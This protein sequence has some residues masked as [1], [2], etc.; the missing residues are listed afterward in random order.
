MEGKEHP[1]FNYD[2]GWARAIFP[3]YALSLS[4][5]LYLSLLWALSLSLSSPLGFLS[6]SPPSGAYRVWPIDDDKFG[7]PSAGQKG[8]PEPKVSLPLP[9]LVA[10]NRPLIPFFAVGIIVCRRRRRKGDEG[11]QIS[12]IYGPNGQKLQFYGGHRYRK[13]LWQK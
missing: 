7:R 2:Q 10:T 4:L 13:Y 12:K 11:T 3:L 5:R 6:L 1:K 9:L 8:L